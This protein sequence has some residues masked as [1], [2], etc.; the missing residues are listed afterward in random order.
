MPIRSYSQFLPIFTPPPFSIDLF[1]PGL[2]TDFYRETGF[3]NLKPLVPVA[4]NWRISVF[5]KRLHETDISLNVGDDVK[6]SGRD[7]SIIN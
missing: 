4:P 5:E 2:I 6:R 3:L 7:F 1:L